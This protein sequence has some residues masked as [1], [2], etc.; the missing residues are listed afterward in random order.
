MQ[1]LPWTLDFLQALS[2]ELPSEYKAPRGSLKS[3]ADVLDRLHG[4]AVKLV[5]PA[6]SNLRNPWDKF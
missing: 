1:S 4:V 6:A 2:P 5:G 3:R